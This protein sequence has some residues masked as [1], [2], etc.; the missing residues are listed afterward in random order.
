MK[1]RMGWLAF[2]AAGALLLSACT[3]DNVAPGDEVAVLLSVAPQGGAVGVAA[4]TTVVVT[5]DHPMM[6]D[7]AEYAALHEGEV[8]GPAVAGTWVLASDGRSLTFTPATPLKPATRY[9][10]HLGGGMRGDHGEATDF[11]L[12]GGAHMGGEWATGAMMAGGG[13]MGA[14]HMGD[15]WRHENGSYGMLFSFT[16]AGA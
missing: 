14:Q 11:D 16:T 9:T 2:T 7:L 6:A 3:E 13:M 8:T 10:V 5:F 12:H 1:T 15:G 4:N